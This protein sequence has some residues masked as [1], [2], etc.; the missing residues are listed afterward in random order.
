MSE[1][2]ARTTILGSSSVFKFR[3]DYEQSKQLPIGEA[4]HSDVVSA[5]GHLW[6]IDF[7][8]RGETGEDNDEYTSIFLNHLSK[9]CSVNAIFEAFMIDRDAKPSKSFSGARMLET[10]EIME[11]NFNSVGWTQFIKITT[12]EEKILTEGQVTFVCAIMVI[13]DSP[14]PVPPSDICYPSWPPTRSN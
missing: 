7:Y 10:F 3:V 4:V 9:S 6:R 12:L 1:P 14:I 2:D 13:D 8:P 11:D 5:G